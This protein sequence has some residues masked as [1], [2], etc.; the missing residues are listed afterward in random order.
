METFKNTFSGTF[1][2]IVAVV[3]IPTLCCIGCIGCYFLLTL[4]TSAAWFV[5]PTY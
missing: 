3:L 2:I 5:M 4:V 1:G